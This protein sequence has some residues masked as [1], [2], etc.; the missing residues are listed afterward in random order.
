[1]ADVDFTYGSI[2]VR[3]GG[4]ASYCGT[5]VQPSSP[6]GVE[7]LS[8]TY[9]VPGTA[10]QVI[11]PVPVN[12]NVAITSTVAVGTRLQALD[13]LVV[14]FT[15]TTRPT[16]T[17][18]SAIDESLAIVVVPYGPLTGL[19]DVLIRPTAIGNPNNSLVAAM[20]GAPL[21][22]DNATIGNLPAVVDIDALPTTWGTFGN[23]R[24]NI[25]TYLARWAG[26][27]GEL[28]KG[29]GTASFTPSQQHPG[30]GAAMSALTSESLLLLVSTEDAAKRRT[31][32][33][34]MTQWGVDLF[35]A[36]ASGRD[37]KADGGHMQ[38]R[39]ALVVLA[40]HLLESEA[41]A[42]PTAL[43][44]GQFNEDEQFYT[45]SPAWPWGWPY[46]Y[47][48]HSDYA[49]NL[50]SPVASWNVN[51]LYYLPRYFG[52][53]VMGTQIG[54]AV[55]MRILGR[56]AEMGTGHYGM[57]AQWMT[58]PSAPDLAAMAAVSTSP[59]LSGINWSTSY[60]IGGGP[61]D[62]GRAAWEAYGDYVPDEEPPPTAP[63][64]SVTGN[65]VNIVNGDD[66][67]D[68]AD[69]TSFGSTTAGGST[70]SRT[71]T[72]AN[73][74][75]KEL[76]IASVTVPSGYT[77]TTAPTSPV[78]V[79]G[80][81]T[82]VVRLDASVVGSKYGPVSIVSD[83]PNAAKFE[84]FVDGTVSSSG[85]G[86][87]GPSPL[88]TFPVQHMIRLRNHSAFPFSG[89]KRTTIET[90]D[91][92]NARVRVG[93]QTGL[94]TWAAD[95]WCDLPPGGSEV[96]DPRAPAGMEPPSTPPPADLLGWFGGYPHVAGQQM[97]LLS[98][99]PD[100]AG[101]MAHFRARI[102]RMFCVDL[103]VLWYP[104]RPAV[105][106]GELLVTC[107]NPAVPDMGETLPALN[108]TWGTSSVVSPSG[109]LPAGMP[110]AD[111]QA[112]ALPLTFVWKDH[113]TTE[114]E[115]HYAAVVAQR[116]M[117]AVG[118]SSLPLGIPG[119]PAGFQPNAWLW[120]H[121][122]IGKILTT[123][124]HPELGPAAN[125]AQAGAQE[126]QCFVGGECFTPDG[127]GSELLTY[128]A[129]LATSGHP[130]HHLE[131]DGSVVDRD[132]H[133]NLRM[134]HS[135]PD[136]RVS[137]DMLGKPRMIPD[138]G[139]A[140]SETHGWNGPD[141]QHWMIGRLAAAAHLTG[142]PVCQRLL[143]HQA[144]TYLIQLTTNQALSTSAIWS[145]REIG[146]EGLAVVQL[147]RVLE[148]RQLAQRV[149]DHFRERVARII[150]P[151]LS[152]KGGRWVSVRADSVGPGECWQAWQH[153]HGSYGLDLACEL[154]GLP[155]GRALA[156]E[157]AK[158]CMAD[159]WRQEGER[160]VQY[161]HLGID[162]PNYRTHDKDFDVAWSGLA[163]AT[164]LRHE[165]E[166]AQA[167]SIWQQ[168]RADANGDGRWLPNL[169]R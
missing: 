66:T 3:L 50:S 90:Q 45:A 96:V 2:T 94:E 74:G 38:G 113:I 95:V 42:N 26:F 154:F 125:T 83:D 128:F 39:K 102:G 58:G 120:R 126:D 89:W 20:R 168:M 81:T 84:F 72:I 73:T 24:P 82:L 109:D 98:L 145:A 36:F 138:A 5:M 18:Y 105:V 41:L 153:A 122:H 12:D 97:H 159:S 162:D 56:T 144:R 133:P 33:Y 44:P 129:A 57:V 46:G 80:S 164:V 114:A 55:A 14:L 166:N 85:G 54:C 93:R 86:S 148:D 79:S 118:V 158:R 91:A 65:G 169:T 117:V 30:Y 53:E 156:L 106:D 103:V 75:T 27:C 121:L 115:A 163:I 165:P 4:V 51:V 147:W 107:S 23:D 100:G 132:R 63:R 116:T 32:G 139:E 68:P 11:N 40:G 25:D 135:R 136:S 167:L 67:P 146:W 130:C 77:L 111:G 64:I 157:C 119:M 9:A 21:V 62:F 34:R 8:Y 123:W 15:R 16:P 151:K 22:F 149:V 140:T 1:M 47:R 92:S 35:G 152:G 137:P 104:E 71:F 131:L 31:L 78:A 70:I 161:G 29:W 13:S 160:W 108:L 124:G 49:W 99:R 88:P 127:L 19:D 134:F 143:E 112:R 28:W 52:Q 87:G 142:S 76:T 60:S 150:V 7:I 141:A 6:A 48:G 101:H 69:H 10:R 155:E 61:Q 59:P 43:F 17:P 37:D 110:F